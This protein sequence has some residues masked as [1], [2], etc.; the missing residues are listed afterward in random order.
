MRPRT[1]ILNYSEWN[2]LN[3]SKKIG[4]NYSRSLILENDDHKSLIPDWLEWTRDVVWEGDSNSATVFFVNSDPKLQFINTGIEDKVIE[5]QFKGAKCSSASGRYLTIK[6]TG[7][8]YL[9]CLSNE[10]W[11][12]Y[13]SKEGV[14]SKST[15]GRFSSKVGGIIFKEVEKLVGTSIAAP[16]KDLPKEINGD[17]AK[18]AKETFEKFLWESKQRLSWTYISL[19]NLGIIDLAKSDVNKAIE[20]KFKP[21]KLTIKEAGN[22]I[23]F[24]NF[25]FKGITNENRNLTLTSGKYVKSFAIFEQDPPS[26]WWPKLCQALGIATDSQTLMPD[27]YLRVT[28]YG[29]TKWE[30]GKIKRN[31][32]EV[33]E[34]VVFG[35]KSL[36]SDNHDKL[37]KFRDEGYI[38]YPKFLFTQDPEDARVKHYLVGIKEMDETVIEFDTKTGKLKTWINKVFTKLSNIMGATGRRLIMPKSKKTIKAWEEIA[39]A[40]AD[41]LK[42]L[43]SKRPDKFK[44]RSD[45]YT[46]EG[47]A[48]VIELWRTDEINEFDYKRF[49]SVLNPWDKETQEL[50]SQGKESFRKEDTRNWIDKLVDD[51]EEWNI[52]ISRQLAQTWIDTEDERDDIVNFIS[53]AWNAT[54]LAG[55]AGVPGF[56]PAALIDELPDNI[57]SWAKD[58][59]EAVLEPYHI[60]LDFSEVTFLI[61]ELN[62]PAI[63]KSPSMPPTVLGKIG[64]KISIT[65][66]SKDSK[67][68]KVST[69]ISG[70]IGLTATIDL[71]KKSLELAYKEAW[72][73]S[74]KIDLKGMLGGGESFWTNVA[75][76]LLPTV[77]INRNLNEDQNSKEFG[78]SNTSIDFRFPVFGTYYL[79]IQKKNR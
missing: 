4:S 31:T 5:I 11:F 1:A 61:T 3:E 49:R 36:D 35:E 50:E 60:D 21:V 10:P 68:K 72:M 34:E 52:D 63:S 32:F 23:D 15:T 12:L 73:Q 19:Y 57:F 18:W 74:E 8:N 37:Q 6:S 26:L 16:V 41:L 58:T 42:T 39:M 66:W 27:S 54:V 9:Y 43:K 64:G 30:G 25:K 29:I 24:Y 45:V 53:A 44:R 55:K 77:I 7:N 79:S 51:V 38:Y 40:E 20:Q 28:D 47:L 69:S 70:D 62:N 67:K 13:D 2:R 59:A 17:T 71:S 48:A 33:V 65:T 56:G 22:P 78:E 14:N 75:N 76:N 46:P